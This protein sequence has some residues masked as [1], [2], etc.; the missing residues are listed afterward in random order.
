MI[1]SPFLQKDP[2]HWPLVAIV[3]ISA[4]GIGLLGIG[5]VLGSVALSGGQV[6]ETQRPTRSAI[7]DWPIIMP[8]PVLT[9][10]AAAIAVVAVVILAARVTVRTRGTLSTTFGWTLAGMLGAGPLAFAFPD[11]RV[12]ESPLVPGLSDHAPAAAAFALAALISLIGQG[13]SIAAARAARAAGLNPAFLPIVPPQGTP[14]VPELTIQAPPMWRWTAEHGLP[15]IVPEAHRPAPVRIVVP[16]REAGPI[17][18]PDPHEAVVD[19]AP[20]RRERIADG[21]G[22]TIMRYRFATPTSGDER[23]VDVRIRPTAD[24]H[25]LRAYIDCADLIAGSVRWNEPAAAPARR[26]RWWARS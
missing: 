1:D 6:T 9:M 10:A 23:V 24:R 15:S 12:G 21:S 11:A 14:L 7:L 20:A 8:P 2:A 19:D 4:V 17:T 16:D 13:R 3:G 18:D 25:E 22:G 5:F 26:R